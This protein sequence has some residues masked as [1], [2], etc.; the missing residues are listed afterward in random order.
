MKTVL[1]EAET[2]PCQ[3]YSVN[4]SPFKVDVTYSPLKRMAGGKRLSDTP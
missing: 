3:C 4:P 1:A 2:A